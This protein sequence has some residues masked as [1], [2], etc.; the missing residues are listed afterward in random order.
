VNQPFHLCRCTCGVAAAAAA[1]SRITWGLPV[2][3]DMV[4][5]DVT[6]FPHTL[7]FGSFSCFEIFNGWIPLLNL[8]Q[9]PVRAPRDGSG[10]IRNDY[11]AP[12]YFC[13]PTAVRATN[14][15]EIRMDNQVSVQKL[16]RRGRKPYGNITKHLELQAYVG[17][18]KLFTASCFL[19]RP[20]VDDPFH[21]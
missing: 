14:Q 18:Y 17:I 20:K 1:A 15:I 2:N 16:Q 5:T 9:K 13:C 8:D 4:L 11:D 3:V 6:S 7:H 10:R 12:S 19:Q 21:N